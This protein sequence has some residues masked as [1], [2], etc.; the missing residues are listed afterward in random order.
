MLARFIDAKGFEDWLEV[1][2]EDG[3]P[4]RVLR[5]A[6]REPMHRVQPL[7]TG[8]IDLDLT[9]DSIEFRLFRWTP[10]YYPIYREVD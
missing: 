5:L 8:P 10:G 1:V 7:S 3:Y 4:P 9:F 2:P 6:V